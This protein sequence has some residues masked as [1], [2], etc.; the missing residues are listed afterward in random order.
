MRDPS[1]V[2]VPQ[3]I[4]GTRSASGDYT[5]VPAPGIGKRLVV[6]DLTLQNEV[7]TAN[8]MILKDGSGQVLQRFK[9][10]AD[11]SFICPVLGPHNFKRAAENQPLVLN[12]SA[13]TAMG[14]TVGYFTETI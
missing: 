7:G 9:G 11:G 13:A 4:S 6:V 10:L 2:I 1:I 8:V 5:L 14:Y 3:Y 12:L